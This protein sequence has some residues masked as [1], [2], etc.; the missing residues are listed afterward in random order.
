MEESGMKLT[1]HAI[2]LMR[3]QINAEP[4]KPDELRRVKG[5]GN[6]FMSPTRFSADEEGEFTRL[7]WVYWEMY[8]LK[9]DGTIYYFYGG[10]PNPTND[11]VADPA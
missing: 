4:I 2:R 8:S 9:I 1:K 7:G 11:N 10:S 6:L 5:L 3:K